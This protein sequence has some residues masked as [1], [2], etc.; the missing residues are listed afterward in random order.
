MAGKTKKT[1]HSKPKKIMKKKKVGTSAHSKKVAKIVNSVSSAGDNDN[2]NMLKEALSD[3][4]RELSQLRQEKNELEGTLDNVAG[5]ITST[6]NKEVQIK[7][8]LRKLSSVEN[9]LALKRGRVR[10]QLENVKTKI[11]KVRQLSAKMENM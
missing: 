8:Q 10:K 6:Q 4:A 7:D 11:Q 2:H 1:K 9:A 5:D 3:I